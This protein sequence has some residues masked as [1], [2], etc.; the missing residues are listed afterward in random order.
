MLKTAF[1]AFTVWFW[2]FSEGAGVAASGR[3]AQAKRAALQAA[4]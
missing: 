4:P 3:S 1:R 2:K